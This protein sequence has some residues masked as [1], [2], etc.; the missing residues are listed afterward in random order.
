MECST[1]SQ[2]RQQPQQYPPL[3]STSPSISNSTHSAA[4]VFNT[5]S[6][7]GMNNN[8]NSANDGN[9]LR[10]LS[11]WNV[12]RG[13]STGVADNLI[14]LPPPAVL[15]INNHQQQYA[16]ICNDSRIAHVFVDPTGC[17][18]LLSSFNGE[19]YY[20]HSS[21]K[22]VRKLMGFGPNPGKKDIF[23]LYRKG[24]E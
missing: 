22:K 11:R 18:T 7:K 21:I 8:N 1:I 5:H 24:K 13:S 12:R 14:T 17:H 4:A 16:T 15:L 9:A 2:Q 6:R 10:L 19:A 23:F 20:L 3:P